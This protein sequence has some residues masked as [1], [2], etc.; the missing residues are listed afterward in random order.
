MARGARLIISLASSL[1]VVLAASPGAAQVAE[2]SSSTQDV[3]R[4]AVTE[5]AELYRL[6]KH[7][8]FDE[9]KLGNYED[10]PAHWV[11]LR[12]EGLPALY[13]KGRFDEAIGHQAAPSFRLDIASGNVAYEYRHL[14]L[15]VVP[16]SDYVL[17]GHVRAVG[18]EF[19]AAFVAAY[20]VDRFG[21]L[22][23]GSQRISSLIRA[24][25]S[26]P[27]PWQRVEI[28]LPGEFPMAYALRLQFW[29]LQ[30]YV[31]RERDPREVDPII[32]RDVYG[33]AWFDDFSVYRLP[34]VHLR[35]SNPA[36]LVLPGRPEELILEVN[37]AT[38]QPLQ[39]ELRILDSTGQPRHTQKLDVP[40]TI[41]PFSFAVPDS[42]APGGTSDG[43]A[44][45]ASGL[46]NHVAA[47]RAAVPDLA[48]GLYA[49]VLQL[50]GGS[51]VLLERRIRFAVLPELPAK[52]PHIPDIGVDLGRWQRG[53]IA[54]VGELLADLGCGAIKIGIPMVGALDSEEKSSYFQ[55]LSA[56]IRVL[57]ENRVEATGVL[58]AASPANRAQTSDSI[59]Y[60]VAQDD[61]WHQLLGPILAY[62]GALLPTWQLGAEDVELQGAREWQPDDIERVRSA[63]CQFITIPRL[64]IP[65]PITALSPPKDDLVSV[66]IP[67]NL[68]TRMLPRQLEFLVNGDASSY[69]L[70]LAADPRCDLSSAWRA[71]DLARRLVLAKALNPGRVFLP[72]PFEL[73]TSGGQ[74]EWQPTEDYLVLR[75]LFHYLSGKTAIAAMTPAADT[76]AVVF[77]G[78][79]SSCTVIWSWREDA[80]PE[81]IELYLGPNPRAINIWGQPVPLEITQGRTRLP[82]G[83]TPLIVE[84]LH[85]P[86][87]LLQAS[88]RI[89]PTYVE[90]HEPEPRPVLTFRN[91]FDAPLSGEVRLTPPEGWAVTPA[92]RTFV[93]EPGETLA[94]PLTFTLPPWQIAQSYDLHV[95]LILHTPES[96]ELHFQ[97][98]LTVGLRD[99]ALQASAH[100]EGNDLVVEQSLRNRSDQPV[101]F[102]AFC[103]APARARQENAFLNIMPGELA[104]QTYVFRKSRDLAGAKLH[105][106][107]QEIGGERSLNQFAEVPQ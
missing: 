107:I 47:V 26:D 24:T 5:R 81:P 46:H 40:A 93:L 71:D 94:E 42:P 28:A 63:F 33:T 87:A 76:L 85:T 50:L 27:E 11:Q 22:V 43:Q 104:L 90:I 25:G 69:W 30:D 73:S 84:Q 16:E 31:W 38:P 44:S 78:G 29:I 41:V 75:T 86:L 96:T 23:P 51:E 105:M 39:A 102:T 52:A 19:A 21:E 83:P 59:R 13:A 4:A 32:R 70:Q 2:P 6:V 7:F 8:D 77:E 68:P 57:G 17:V 98:P 74:P 45:P 67:A 101:S 99:I 3:P 20:F 61:S 91:T 56:L 80:L 72:A 106:G 79:G 103:D 82:V 58:L 62:F 97:Q 37:N 34:R 35:L 10:T 95:K 53:E 9:R 88:Y 49:A 12:G 92:A 64:V 100:W 66:W 15:T 89:A 55:Q 36:G 1:C 54:G 60:L 14:D 65:Q 48:P 18:L